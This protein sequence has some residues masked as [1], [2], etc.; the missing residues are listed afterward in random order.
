MF[1]AMLVGVAEVVVYAAY[2]RKAE[3]AK[4]K[5]RKVV[6]KKVVIGEYKGGID[7]TDDDRS[8]P[9]GTTA[10]KVEIWGKGVNGGARRRLRERWKERED[11]SEFR[12]LGAIH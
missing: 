9:V 8:V 2:W 12:S 10:E 7:G 5:E 6:E 11:G 3:A 4:E 1:L